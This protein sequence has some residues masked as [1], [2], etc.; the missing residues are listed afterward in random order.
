MQ[1][2]ETILYLVDITADA[3]KELQS[4]IIS[5]SARPTEEMCL[6]KEYQL[7]FSS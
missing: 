5:T 6:P 3:E 1:S 7:T 2:G 4:F